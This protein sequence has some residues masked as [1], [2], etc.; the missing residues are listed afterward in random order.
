VIINVPHFVATERATWTELEGMLARLESDS[1]YKMNLAELRRFHFLY[2]K[3]SADLA[4]LSTFAFEP[5]IRRYLESLVGRTYG[6]IHETR[7]RPRLTG[8]WQV[9]WH[10]FPATFQRHVAAF[11]LSTA[12]LLS[13]TLFGAVALHVD[14]EAKAVLLPF[15]HLRGDPA[16]R[17]AREEHEKKNRISGSQTSFSAFLM[18]HNIRVSVFTLSAGMTAGIGTVLLLFYNGIILGAVA[19]DYI[20]AGQTRFL[21]GWLLPHGVIEIPAILIAGQAGLLLGGAILGWKS[22]ASLGQRFRAVGRDLVVLAF[23]LGVMLIWA[24]IIEAFFSQWH[25]PVMPY[26]LKIGFGV[27]ELLV[28]VLFLSKRGGKPADAGG[29]H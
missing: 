7:E 26:G 29:A 20:T 12:L 15:S 25:E 4:R 23:G 18:T 22:Q 8:I 14:P 1:A 11:W 28:L 6:E 19:I 2:Q 24:G 27:V 3:T 13:G 16:Q 9:F 5:Q 10:T 17:V 21:L